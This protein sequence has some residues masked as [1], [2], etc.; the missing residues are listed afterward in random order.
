MRDIR[1]EIL[2]HS[3]GS[4]NFREVVKHHHDQLDASGQRPYGRSLR[5]KD[6]IGLRHEIDGLGLRTCKSAAHRLF[7]GGIPD[8]FHRLPAHRVH[9]KVEERADR[10]VGKDDAGIA[11]NPDQVKA[12]MEGGIVHAISAALWG[13]ITFTAGV[14]AQTNYNKN[15]VLK[16]KEM[17]QISVQI[18]PSQNAPTGT[19]EPGV[20]AIA[21]AIANAYARLTGTR[22]T[23]LP[24]FPGALMGGL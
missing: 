3:F 18:I 14:A 11:V 5:Q 7:D 13:Q 1:D 8:K 23:N 2:P 17:P 20:P 4:P 16:L 6:A 19:G 22:V 12:Q 10:I 21:P 24:F 9:L 15:R